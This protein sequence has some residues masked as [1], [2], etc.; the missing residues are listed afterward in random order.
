LL[1]S[2]KLLECI[3]QE[4]DENTLIEFANEQRE[5]AYVVCESI[6]AG[7]LGFWSIAF[8]IFRRY[9]SDE[10]VKERLQYAIRRTDVPHGVM[11]GLPGVALQSRLNDVERVLSEMPLSAHERLWLRDVER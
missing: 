9:S 1:L 3:N 2:D 6:A 11:I 5:Q 8:E 4:L 10:Y 7:K